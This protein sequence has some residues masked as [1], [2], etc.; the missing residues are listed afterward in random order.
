MRRLAGVIGVCCALGGCNT[1]SAYT[2]VNTE[3]ATLANGKIQTACAI[4]SVAQ[5]YFKELAPAI[6]AK[7]QVAYR[8][9][10]TIVAAICNNPPKD[11]VSALSTLGSAWMQIQDAT[12]VP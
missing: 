8:N 7:E 1:I 6:P 2:A 3:L 11:V 4:I 5:G 10:S 9:A 12:K